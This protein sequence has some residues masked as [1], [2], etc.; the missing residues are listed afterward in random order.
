[1][2]KGFLVLLVMVLAAATLGWAD[3]EKKWQGFYVGIN[4]G[5]GRHEA[6]W[7]DNDDDWFGAT[8]TNPYNTILPG[9]TLG[10]NLQN[11]S[12]VIGF[13]ADGAFGLTENIIKYCMDTFPLPATW[14]VTKTDKL[15]F[16]ITMRVRVGFALDNA[17][18]Y[19]TAGAGLPS[20]AHTWIEVGD[21]P[22]SWKTFK[23]S[24]IGMVVGLGFEHRLGQALSF[25]AEFLSFKNQPKIQPNKQP[26]PFKMAVD[27]S[28][29]ILRIGF[30]VHF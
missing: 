20:A 19:L 11:G 29:G 23:N 6:N 18:F 8:L 3:E 1:M 7:S 17:L 13:E 30:N 26:T 14:Y 25:K 9:G 16:L 10:F 27:E 4:T 21:V 15:E 5:L 2:K 28:V 24:N 12:V 22:D